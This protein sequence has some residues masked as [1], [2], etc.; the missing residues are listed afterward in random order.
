MPFL[1]LRGIKNI[2]T[3]ER[4]KRPERIKYLKGMKAFLIIKALFIIF[5]NTVPHSRL[6]V[7]PRYRTYKLQSTFRT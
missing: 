3:G 5:S 6:L 4:S 1:I 2:L 7:R